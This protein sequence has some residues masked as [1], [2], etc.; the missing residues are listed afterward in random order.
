MADVKPQVVDEDVTEDAR[1]ASGEAAPKANEAGPEMAAEDGEGL[2]DPAEFYAEIDRLQA[3]RDDMR[4]R[5]MRALAD[6]ENTRKRGERDRREA[7]QYGGS[8][9]ARDLLPV[10]DN[11]ARALEQAT[12]EQKEQGRAF[13]E[14]VELTLRELT[15]VF[16]KHG[17]T[18]VEPQV[19]DA[20]DPQTHQAM[21]RGAGARHQGGRDHPG[22]GGGVS[23]PRPA[24]AAGAGG[25]QLEHR[26]LRRLPHRPGRA[27]GAPQ[28]AAGNKRPLRPAPS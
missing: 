8:K 15:H 3:E 20:F 11:L 21:F 24:V 6:A 9:L 2:V 10:Y 26:R 16:R 22:G 1:P 27:S 19:G 25:G 17:I 4:D 18:P 23:A 5:F 12:E 28:A 14:G 7:E 13:F